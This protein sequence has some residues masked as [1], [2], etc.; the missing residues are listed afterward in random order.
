M[1]GAVPKLR[2]PGFAG[3]WKPT[4]V[5]ALID[6]VALPVEVDPSETYREIGVRSHGKGIFHKEEAPGSV[7]GEK[8]VFAVVPDALVL[9]IV[10]AWEQAVAVTTQADAGFIASHRFPMFRPKPGKADLAFLYRFF[11]TKKGKALLELASPGGAGRNKTLGQQEFLKLKTPA[12]TLPEQE[13]IA[14]FLGAVDGKIS[15][16]RRKEEGL[17]RFKAG[18]MQKLFS[19]ELRFTRDDGSDF[20]DWQE[21]SLGEIGTFRKGKGVS[22]D[23]IALD[24][25]TPCIRYGELYTIYSEVISAAVSRTNVPTDD[26]VLSKGGEIIIPAS[27]ETPEDMARASYVAEAGIALGGDINIFSSPFGGPF[28]AHFLTHHRR[29]QIAKIA[30]GNSVVHLYAA[31]LAS[32]SVPLPHRDEQRKI[33][34]AL[35]AL[36]GKIAGV[37]A[38]IGGLESFKKGLLQQMFV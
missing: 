21:K 26:L 29:N 7:L 12:P 17:K 15:G 16:L 30:Q 38:Q 13:K 37:R 33:A 8:R 36:D 23:D 31:Q 20:P 9:N 10:F 11:M 28:L 19:Q 18:L 27:G 24:G 6:R 5:S 1:S 2:F 35:A 22:K 4:A 25:I 14:G 34:G 3:E 32:L